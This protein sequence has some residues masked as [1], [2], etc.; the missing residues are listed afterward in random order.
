MQMAITEMLS[1]KRIIVL[2]VIGNTERQN[3]DNARVMSRGGYV[4]TS[5]LTY[6]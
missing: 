6:R 4:T 3:R 5:K 1:E 2:G